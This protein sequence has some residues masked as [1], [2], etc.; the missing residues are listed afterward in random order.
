MELEISNGGYYYNDHG[1]G[2][3]GRGR[4]GQ[5]TRQICLS[6]HNLGLGK[7]SNRELLFSL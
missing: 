1:I 2:T 3:A 4:L 6:Q 5:F 7:Q